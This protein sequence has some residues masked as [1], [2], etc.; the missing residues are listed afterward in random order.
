MSSGKK[1][2]QYLAAVCVSIGAFGTGSVIGWT[3]NICEDLKNGKLNELEMDDDQLG[4]SGSCM[5]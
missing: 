1:F 3:S 5:T 4:W 2:P